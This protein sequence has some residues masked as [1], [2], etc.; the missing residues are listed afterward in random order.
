M[1]ATILLLAALTACGGSS[2]PDTP[3]EPAPAADPAPPPAADPAPAAAPSGEAA[4]GD[5]DAGKK[6]YDTY[7]KACH[8]EDGTG[9]N[10]MLAANF[11]EDPA[12]LDQPDEVL[13]DV[14]ANGK[15]GTVGMMLPWGTTLSDQEM[16]DVL[17]YVKASFAQ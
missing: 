7:C 1:R 12:R 15:T 4:A 5:S 17:A 6:V 10:G 2:A 9:M 14:I 3:P 11:K 13:L 16:V 8:Q